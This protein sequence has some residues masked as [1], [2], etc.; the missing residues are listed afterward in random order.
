MI[1]ASEQGTRVLTLNMRGLRDIA[2][3]EK[4]KRYIREKIERKKH[5]VI[6]ILTET[7]TKIEDQKWL[8]D[9]FPT[10]QL[11]F[12]HYEGSRA[13]AGVL[14]MVPQELRVVGQSNNGGGAWLRVTVEG[15]RERPVSIVGVYFKTGDVQMRESQMRAVQQELRRVH[16][17]EH[18]LVVG[19]DFNFVVD[20]SLD[21]VPRV[22]PGHATT[23]GAARQLDWQHKY[24]LVDAWRQRHPQKFAFTFRTGHFHRRGQTQTRIDRILISRTMLASSKHWEVHAPRKW[25]RPADSI[26]DHGYVVGTL[27]TPTVERGPG[28]WKLN[29]L[30]LEESELVDRVKWYID[31]IPTLGVHRYQQWDTFKEIVAAECRIFGR[32]R[33]RRL[34]DQMRHIRDDR[35]RW[36]QAGHAWH[37]G[38]LQQ[39]A[40]LVSKCHDAACV[41]DFRTHQVDGAKLLAQQSHIL[42]RLDERHDSLRDQLT[43][44][45]PDELVDEHWSDRGHKAFFAQSQTQQTRQR[46]MTSMQS[47]T[48]GDEE[49]RVNDS[50]SIGRVVRSF[51]YKLWGVPPR[52][53]A[54]KQERFLARVS[55]RLSAQAARTLDM[56]ITVSEVEK[57]IRK[58]ARG[59]TPGHDGLS[60]EFYHK[61]VDELAPVLA[62][63]Y[64]QSI[65]HEKLP[66]SMCKTLVSLLF[67]DKPGAARDNPACYR[68]IALTT[69]DYKVLAKVLTLR[70]SKHM[71]KLV[72]PDQT[73]FISAKTRQ[74]SGNCMLI[75][76]IA[77]ACNESHTAVWGLA[78]DFHKAYDS[79]S[80]DWLCRVLRRFG[81]GPMFC[82]AVRTLYHGAVIVVMVNGFFT[83]PIAQCSGI[84]QGCPLSCFLFVLCVEP[85][86][87][88]FRAHRGI[89]GVP[90]PNGGPCVH[91]S[92][93]VDDVTQLTDRAAS[94]AV[95]IQVTMDFG[96]CSGLVMNLKKT[97]GL[98]FGP[99]DPPPG[100]DALV[101]GLR[102][103]RIDP[104]QSPDAELP[105]PLIILGSPVGDRL[106]QMQVFGKILAR[107]RKHAQMLGGRP[108]NR[109][110]RA[111]LWNARVVA[112]LSYVSVVHTMGPEV[113]S[114]TRDVGHR[115][116]KGSH[117][118]ASWEKARIPARHGGFGFFEPAFRARAMKALLIQ[119]WQ[120]PTQHER[121]PWCRWF[122][123]FAQ[124]AFVDVARVVQVNTVPAVTNQ[125]IFY[126]PPLEWE[127]I[128]DTLQTSLV[129]E[130]LLL[131]LILCP[132]KEYV[133]WLKP[134]ASRIRQWSAD[135]C[136]PVA[137][138]APLAR[139]KRVQNKRRKNAKLQP[140]TLALCQFTPRNVYRM[141]IEA[142]TRAEARREVARSYPPARDLLS[143]HVCRAPHLPSAVRSHWVNRRNCRLKIPRQDTCVR[144]H[145][146][147]GRRGSWKH[148]L[149]TC[150][151]LPRLREALLDQFRIAARGTLASD[152]VAHFRLDFWRCIRDQCQQRSVQPPDPL[153]P[154][155]NASSPDYKRTLAKCEFYARFGWCM[156]RAMLDAQTNRTAFDVNVVAMQTRIDLERQVAHEVLIRGFDRTAAKWQDFFAFHDLPNADGTRTLR[157]STYPHAPNNPPP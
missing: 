115:L 10:H 124:R 22:P 142:T 91:A 40:D 54:R 18:E 156:Y 82:R 14:I 93:F 3:R 154:Y 31:R 56:P 132:S 35:H 149:D 151:A 6:A 113:Q 20:P 28:Y 84:R 30:H 42:A 141:L 12:S 51:W 52:V 43:Y 102:W 120:H 34:R 69:A 80:H 109:I 46:L 49:A 73:G 150:P 16:R 105:D 127:F 104:D 68:P 130:V 53:S 131:W 94:V 65:Y 1:S 58:S 139:Y 97:E 144:C 27:T 50:E 138:V 76:C 88:A 119:Q 95:A 140:V 79:V 5:P 71:H 63:V 83:S 2:K 57:A 108:Y 110:Q 67:K 72:H 116:L 153:F 36:I 8:V 4:K 21:R 11:C 148:F 114:L 125:R 122:D 133:A 87:C 60:M 19:G 155:S 39:C 32:Q 126:E 70:L 152:T 99:A 135:Q 129:H 89:R 143:N 128:D 86:L 66:A 26:T 136:D 62:D 7:H 74:I 13:Q 134:R 59:K 157:L 103:T 77:R 85:L 15:I 98:L 37:S 100:L 101:R 64:N 48:E 78:I 17:Q 123:E 106:H 25:R 92:A 121:P 111:L 112:K 24:D 61:F 145:A 41:F 96:E 29:T 9:A 33:A 90:A 146:Y 147:V 118:R 38:R 81:F 107:M 75:R 137:L 55:R 47:P 45:K 117:H 44:V 23:K